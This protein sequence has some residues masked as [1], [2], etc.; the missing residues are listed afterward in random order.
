M[1]YMFFMVMEILRELYGSGTRART[2][3]QYSDYNSKL[4][5]WHFVVV[6]CSSCFSLLTPNLWKLELLHFLFVTWTKH[7]NK[8]TISLSTQIFELLTIIIIIIIIIIIKVRKLKIRGT[9]EDGARKR[10]RVAVYTCTRCSQ[11]GHNSSSCKSKEQ[12][13]NGLKRKVIFVFMFHL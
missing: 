3:P 7:A 9:D 1:F 11:S 13:P 10:K 8:H 4:K 5:F 12:C 6:T 2:L